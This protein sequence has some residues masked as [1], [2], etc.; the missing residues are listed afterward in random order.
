MTKGAIAQL[1][2][3][4]CLIF[5]QAVVLLA[6][7]CQYGSPKRHP[8]PD[9]L[10]EALQAAHPFTELPDVSRRG[11][12]FFYRKYARDLAYQF[13]RAWGRPD[14]TI[15]L[16]KGTR[17]YKVHDYGLGAVVE[18]GEEAVLVVVRSP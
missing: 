4:T 6:I 12:Y 5:W 3:T 7:G 16:V 14:R 13:R 15:A 1:M 10:V 18:S 9:H 17:F 11:K 8:R 2:S